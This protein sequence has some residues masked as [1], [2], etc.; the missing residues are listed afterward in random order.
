MPSIRPLAAIVLVSLLTACGGGTE[1][2]VP[3]LPVQVPAAP[4]PP[5]DPP[6]PP[7]PEGL[8]IGVDE[9]TTVGYTPPSGKALSGKSG[10]Q[11]SYEFVRNVGEI[12]NSYHVLSVTLS[13]PSADDRLSLEVI[14]PDGQSSGR[15]NA[16]D[17]TE[18]VV[19]I[20]APKPGAYRLIVREERTSAGVSFRVRTRLEQLKS[21]AD[22]AAPCL[23]GDYCV[24]AAKARITPAADHIAGV[25]E[26]RLLGAE[27]TRVTQRFHL[28]GFGF[29]PFEPAKTAEALF[30]TDPRLCEP[31]TGSCL[32]NEAAR[33]AAHCPGF[34]PDCAEDE[35]EHTY[36]RALY[37]ALPSADG[38]FGE[39]VLFVTVDAIGAGNLIQDGMKAAISAATGIPESRILIGQTHSHA[40]ADLQGLWGGVPQDWIQHTLYAAAADAATRA[41]QNA[42]WSTLRYASG[43]DGAWNNYRRPRVRPDATADER[44]G[45]LQARD[46]NGAVLG[47][48]LQYAAHPTGIGTG[49][50]GAHG[51]AVHADYVLGLEDAVERVTHAPAIYFNGVIA[52]ASGSGPT[53]GADDYAR[54]RS[55]GECLAA[56]ALALLD[57]AQPT[58]AA[59]EF[60]PQSRRTVDLA[61][62]IGFRQAEATLPITNP[63]F[64]AI[65]LAGGFNR[66]YDFSNLPTEQI[67]F[68]GPERDNLPQLAPVAIT[69]V[70]R[71]TL[72]AGSD[73]L[74]IVTVPGE[75]TNTFGQ[76]VR[77]MAETEHMLLL[78]LTHNSFGY[79]LPEEEFS[80]LNADGDDGF[81]LPFTRYEEFVSLGPLTA[82]LLRLQA[83]APLFDIDADDPRANPAEAACLADPRDPRC[84]ITQLLAEIDRIQKA[85]ASQ[86]RSNFGAAAEPVCALL[87][88]D[89]DL[90]PL[91]DQLG[92]DDDAC[93]VFGQ[94]GGDNGDRDRLAAEAAE[95]ALRGCD[96]LDPSNCLLPFPSNHFTTAAAPGSRQAAGTGI[97][98]NFNPLA[99]PRNRFGKPIDP[100]EWNRNDGFS[101]GQM[102]VTY[103]PGLAANA[104]GTIPGAPPIT[105][106]GRSL[107]VAQSSVVVINAE[108]G[109][110]HPVW[111]EIDLNAG[112]LLPAE[113]VAN[114]VDPRRPALLIRPAKN[115]D[116]G[117]RYIVVLKNLRD[118]DGELIPAQ[119]AFATCRD[120]R[121]TDLPPLAERCAALA[122]V[123]ATV[124]AHV[125]EVAGNP[126]LYL[127]WDFTVASAENQVA[128]LRHMRDDAF[129]RHLGQVEDADGRIVD[130]GRAPAFTVDRVTPN[131]KPGI[132]KRIEGSFTVPSYVTPVDPAPGDNHSAWL[133]SLCDVIP[134]PDFANGCR[135]LF[136]GVGIVDGASAPPN[137]LFYNPAD[138]PNPA[139]PQ[140]QRWGD[141]L[142]DSVGTMTTR[143]TCMIPEQAGA[144]NP[145]RPGIYGHGLLDGH[146]AVNYDK[147][148]EFARDHNF[149]FC[150]ADL[151]GFATGDVPNVLSVLVDLSNFP[152]IPDASQQGLL[153]YLFLARLLRHPE[154]FAS[155]PA[156]QRDGEPVFDNTEVFYDG[157]SQGGI[158]GG[159][160][161]AMSKDVQ[162]GVLGVVGMNYSMLLRRS[163]DFD[164]HI[165][166]GELPP[167]ALPL[168]L[169]YT[170]DLDRDL[171]FAL[172]QML[173]D[174]SE[175]NGYAHHISDNRALRGPDNQVL[176][177]PA[178]ADH[179][180]TH[181]SAQ[182]MAR[183]IGVEVADLYH[184]YPDEGEPFAFNDKFEFF[185]QRDPDSAD[186]WDLPL[187]G[188]NARAAYDSAGCQGFGCRSAKSALIEFDQGRT[189]TPPVGNVPPRA[190]NFD[191]HGYPRGTA[192]GMCQ[193]SHFLH[194]QGRIIDTRH[195][196]RVDTAAQC[197]PLPPAI[198]EITA[199]G[200][201]PDPTLLDA[202]RD[203]LRAASQGD[204]QGAIDRVQGVANRLSGDA[205]R[206]LARQIGEL[207]GTRL[208]P[209]EP[210]PA[211]VLAAPQPLLAGVARGEIRVPIGTP[212]GGY[213]RP[214]VAGEYIPGAEALGGGDPSV[215]F[216]ELFDFIPNVGDDGT[217]LAPIPDELRNVHSPYATWSP[218]SRGVYDSLIAKS[219]ALYDGT[220]YLVFVKTDFIGMIDEVVMD[221][222]DEVLARTGKDVREG[223]IMSA[224]HTHDGPGALANHAIRYFWLAMDVYQHDVYRR[225]VGQL[226][227]VVVASLE[228]MQPARIGHAFGTEALG[229]NGYRRAFLPHYDRAAN[230]YVTKRIGVLRV[231]SAVSGEPLAVMIN[232]SAHGIAF[233][234]ENLF[235]SG[236]VLAAVEREVEQGFDTPVTAMLIQSAG[237]NISPRNNLHDNKL[238]RIES[239]GKRLAPQVRAV[240][241]SITEFQTAPDLRAVSQR[242]VLDRDRLGYEDDEFPYEWGAAQCWND[243]EVPF[244]GV[245]PADLPGWAANGGPTK[246]PFC[247][248]GPPP[249]VE[250]LVDNGVAENGAFL[251]QDTRLTAAR[252]GELLILAQPGEPTS[253]Y[254]V[255]ALALAEAE[256]FDAG[257]TFIWGYAQ[258]HVGYILPPEEDDW[259][260]GGTEGTTTFWGWKQGG[261][262]LAANRA[263]IRA[264][265]DGTAAPT[266]EFR[267]RYYYDERY[268]QLPPARPT[269]SRLPGTAVTQPSS[270]ARFERTAFVFEGGDPVIDR[271]QVSLDVRDANGNWRPA[272]RAN[273]APIADL[274]EMHLSYR[275]VSARHLWTVDF[276]APRDWPTGVY[277]IRVSGTALGASSD[278]TL[279]SAPFAVSPA[280]TLILGD[281]I[282]DGDTVSVTLH[283]PTHPDNYRVIDADVPEDRNAPVRGGEVVFRNG[284]DTVVAGDEDGDGVYHA[285][286]TGAVS[287]S[288]RDAYGNTSGAPDADGDGV[289]DAGDACPDSAAG[290]RVD[291]AGCSAAQ[292]GEAGGLLG[293]FGR[294]M[295]DLHGVITALLA[296]DPAGA[297][298]GLAGAVAAFIADLGDP[299]VDSL[300]DLVGLDRPADQ[301]LLRAAGAERDVEP[302]VLRGSDLPAWSVPAA[303]G[304]ANPHVENG[305]FSGRRDAH[306]G[307]LIYPAPGTEA[308]AGAP[309]EHL[310][311]FRWDGERFVEIPVQVDEVMPYF[312]ANPKSG[313]AFYSGTDE[314]YSYAWDVESWKKTAGT[315][316]AEYPPGDGPTPDPVAGID[317]DDEIV[318]MASDA[319][320][321][322]PGVDF[323]AGWRSVQ[324][325][326]L[327]DPLDPIA[328][329]YVY[330]VLRDGGSSFEAGNGYVRYQRRSD[331]D[332]WIDRGF[333]A[334][335]D[336]EK[337]GTSNTGY[338]PNLLGTVCPDGTPASARA[339]SDRFVRDGL[340]VTTD[341]YRWEASGRWM[342]R[343]IRVREPG[344]DSPDPAY[345]ASRTDLIDRWKGR[346]FQQSPDS[347]ISLVGFEDE[348]VNWEANAALL[349]ERCGPVRCMR[350]VWGADSGTNV[351]KLETF[352]R[353]A[354]TYRYRVRVHPIPPDGLYTSWDYNRHAMVSDDPAVPAGRYY[355]VTRPQ[356]VL[357]DGFNDDIGNVDGFNGF[358]AYFDAADP[359]FNLPQGYFNWEQVSG[360]GDSG[361]LVYLFEITGASTPTNPLVVPYYRDDAC[362]DDGTGDDPVP[363]PWPGEDSTDSRVRSGYEAANGGQSYDSL[364]CEQ[365]Q[366]AHGSHG[367]HFFF[368]H[369]SDNAFSPVTS[370]EIDGT[371]WQFMVPTAAPTN[372]G[373]RYANLVKAPLVPTVIPLRDERP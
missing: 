301:Y 272:T 222:A 343:D 122:D 119:A 325:V 245:G 236:D 132:A 30:G 276:E 149:L 268:A 367:V 267:L 98:V 204:L 15:V 183:T 266:D 1:P 7:P 136:E 70:S 233:D 208:P 231:D 340:V 22:E 257:R 64:T 125:T 286:I 104:D 253:E 97:R 275:L 123:L 335:D 357:I 331:A 145:A 166:P 71:V 127:A 230:D 262:L 203:A 207:T 65:G 146:Q 192:H 320:G 92:F 209:P 138:N 346:A 42:R 60:D 153:N 347:T 35:A 312:L 345:W 358:P 371:Q 113:G 86:C 217:P 243:L 355:T 316:Y 43:V 187:V 109:E 51:R 307:R 110:P 148:P 330:L 139:D 20:V 282:R 265:R 66:Y 21:S 197:P 368:T 194:T 225:L 6:A 278:Y 135:D 94:A 48:L 13:W 249:D 270:I 334:A 336:P 354:V 137:R 67:P 269:A 252:I 50:G 261:R 170:D 188:R 52:D 322:Y 216:D 273:G 293:A 133:E 184:R 24:G 227:D 283:Y 39:R 235:F 341:T 210:K 34:A 206:D 129:T 277:R 116:E 234:V 220:D 157:N 324:M 189:A 83:Y 311:A 79:I 45:V 259:K 199:V 121:A 168:Y 4:L 162:R 239:Y 49:S 37:L 29:G 150:G 263:L 298:N 238:Q 300:E 329:R 160:V 23:P 359:S 232:W 151:F 114:P 223:L 130:L 281:P 57:P 105:D 353:D 62:A 254:G 215:F 284:S 81:V 369:D 112:L 315:C 350:E 362:L 372:V 103:V 373:D 26:D 88:P 32:S 310:A 74:E 173:W 14:R 44:L 229:L 303:R 46:S 165:E 177:Q 287:V 214:P 117:T 40:G 248:P 201:A 356:G 295:A 190:D 332:Q 172:M 73:R 141:G 102:I 219:V 167:Y 349:G 193:K 18:Q 120:G 5:L 195:A 124:A 328:Q 255:R 31:S 100:T 161:V 360:K 339:S 186:F 89:T 91:C 309:V 155:H 163:V 213:L 226:A 80:Y 202:V 296:G 76:Q 285:V 351:T 338:G 297:G 84:A 305:A 38:G 224:T 317:H 8:L 144:E 175:N 156:F 364:S 159:A 68:I 140:G 361:S 90:R 158:I 291:A 131:P 115:F 242:I 93:R 246:I 108:T 251:P 299:N 180:V 337:L 181:W 27:Q 185:A 318:F 128:R 11:P 352:Y 56:T 61:P 78:G 228:Q 333:F 256:Q 342:V 2:S 54:V 366:G 279:T 205:L 289:P 143:F 302:V 3:A 321:L 292:R 264:L 363:R 47:T 107:D 240:Y 196:R 280:E 164:N 306:N 327:D 95:A 294:F 348:Q 152:V 304:V 174:R 25:P 314:E 200:Q 19:R 260:L 85:Y 10:G 82:P 323:P 241:D 176:L 75:A 106:I 87:D 211:P 12:A 247:I 370:T 212:L 179:Q 171:G 41:V 178:F 28:G 308:L 77:D 99:M 191:P 17:V 111:A 319:G 290:D 33:R 126:A 258:D 237:G 53:I 250:D 58:C 118:A 36:L 198:R 344:I 63:L 59:S 221:V 101:P 326:A 16:P 274:Y 147:V 182:V 72:G 271:P 142:P 169:S 134:Q 313:F 365:R 96:L 9:G 218:A 55:R 69:A 154:G 244:A 288:G